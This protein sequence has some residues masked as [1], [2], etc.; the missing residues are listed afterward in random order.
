[1]GPGQGTLEKTH[2][3]EKLEDDWNLYYQSVS[4]KVVWERERPGSPHSS[5]PVSKVMGRR[6]EG[7]MRVK[8][9]REVCVCVCVCVLKVIAQGHRFTASQVPQLSHTT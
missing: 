9:Q 5:Y 6:G 4:D 3:W 1:M 8:G 2:P 7:E